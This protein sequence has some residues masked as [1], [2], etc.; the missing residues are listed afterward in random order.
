MMYVPALSGRLSHHAD[1]AAS[2]GRAGVDAARSF[3]TGCFREHRTHDLRG[4]TE[5]ELEVRFRALA[6]R[7]AVE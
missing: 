7:R 3:G 4:L 1:C 5:S 2:V 6:I